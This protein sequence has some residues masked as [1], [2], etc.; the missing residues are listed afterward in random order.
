[1]SSV[2]TVSLNALRPSG[3][4]GRTAFFNGRLLS[5][6]DLQREQALREANER[7]LAR[8]IGCGIEHGL[9]VE[10]QTGSTLLAIAAGLGVT[11]SGYVIEFPDT[12]VDLAAAAVTGARR[13]FASCDAFADSTVRAGLHLL[14]LTPG[15]LSSGHAATLF[16]GD[17]DC[18]RNTEL[19]ASRVR[20]LPLTPP[21]ATSERTLRNEVAFSLLAQLSQAGANRLGWL[22]AS[23]VPSLTQD[24]LPLAVLKLDEQ[25]RI[26]FV[27]FAAVQRPLHVPLDLGRDKFRLQARTIEMEAFVE[28]FLMQLSSERSAGVRDFGAYVVRPSL[29]VVHKQDNE[30]EL[31]YLR[32]RL[33]NPQKRPR[34]DVSRRVQDALLAD[35]IRG[36][37]EYLGMDDDSRVAWFPRSNLGGRPIG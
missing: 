11:P 19:P 20:L 5:A 30:E 12:R 4:L 21:K 26:V 8:L 35:P 37:V 28:Q 7:R 3:G 23:L 34:D 31:S 2:G 14:V 24:D 9:R 27:D 22:P 16:A 17:G 10:G 15:W 1:M 29:V 6:E 13:G 32:S 18:N 36:D 25:A 33:G